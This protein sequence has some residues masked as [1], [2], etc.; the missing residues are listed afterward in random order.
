[1]VLEDIQFIFAKELMFIQVFH[2]IEWFIFGSQK[3]AK[4]R[5]ESGNISRNMF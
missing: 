2:R 1:M 4:Q 3:V 5:I